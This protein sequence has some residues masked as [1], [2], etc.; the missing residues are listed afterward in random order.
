MIKKLLKVFFLNSLF[1]VILVLTLELI[2]HNLGIEFKKKYLKPY[3]GYSVFGRGTYPKNYFIKDDFLGFDINPNSE[4]IFFYSPNGLLKIFSNNFGCFDQ[5]E[6]YSEYIY[7]GGDSFIWG[8]DDY[9]KTF[10]SILE[11]NI[12]NKVAKCGVTNTGQMHQFYKFKN[13]LKKN[14]N[15]P[16]KIII[17]HYKN[18]LN[19]DFL[20]PKDT[21]I[22]GWMVSRP[23]NTKEQ[24][25]ITNL[26]I[27]KEKI[28][29]LKLKD[30]FFYN[31]KNQHWFIYLLNNSF[32]ISA[33]REYKNILSQGKDKIL[34]T[35][36]KK[37]KIKCNYENY[38]SLDCVN[39]NK[40]A[41]NK[42][43]EFSDLNDIDFLI[44]LFPQIND[45]KNNLDTYSELKSYL[46]EEKIDY[47]DLFNQI[48]KSGIDIDKFYNRD[49]HFS[50]F[51]MKFIVNMN[52]NKLL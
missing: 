7:L 22:N 42:F 48:K 33:I 30:N 1:L 49:N 41:I 38:N 9:K 20:F 35:K 29:N 16:K 10:G 14:K 40:I 51:G 13:F 43:A 15:F 26:I 2:F 24:N 44:I 23:K 11:N 3:F 50:E 46:D 27:Q 17:G 32:L 39:R 36:V 4:E 34:N 52:L 47:I 25:R 5:N 18:D 12:K 45:L 37:D 21:V 8:Y 6:N 19:D 31:I 28:H